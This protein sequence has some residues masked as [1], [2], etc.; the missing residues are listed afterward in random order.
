MY[1]PSPISELLFENM[2]EFT[3]STLKVGLSIGSRSR[4]GSDG[5]YRSFP[6]HSVIMK[7]TG[8][9]LKSV[10]S[11]IKSLRDMGFIET[12]SKRNNRGFIYIWCLEEEG[13]DLSRVEEKSDPRMEKSSTR[14][15]KDRTEQEKNNS[16]RQEITLEKLEKVEVSEEVNEFFEIEEVRRSVEEFGFLGKGHFQFVCNRLRTCPLLVLSRVFDL[17]PRVK[18]INN[19]IG[20][21]IFGV[22]T[23]GYKCSERSLERVNRLL[24]VHRGVRVPEERVRKS[25]ENRVFRDPVTVDVRGEEPGMSYS[26]YLKMRKNNVR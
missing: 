19:P 4:K 25:P 9:S 12:V 14:L 2:S 13:E 8:L 24:K 7:D 20:Y 16:T 10:Q 26:E 3:G 1:A 17:L 23:L 15:Y 21:L 5:K 22:E 6:G 11:G 18:T